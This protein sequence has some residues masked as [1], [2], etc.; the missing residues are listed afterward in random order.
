MLVPRSETP[1][2]PS[3]LC[4]PS[5]RS[6]TPIRVPLGQLPAF[7]GHSRQYRHNT[8][9]NEVEVSGN[10]ATSQH[11]NNT[12]ALSSS[13]GYQSVRYLVVAKRELQAAALNEDIHHSVDEHLAGHDGVGRDLEQLHDLHNNNRYQ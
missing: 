7:Q 8:E 13:F 10:I 12:R 9:K 11:H 3:K 6:T 5:I 4:L 1:G 2:F